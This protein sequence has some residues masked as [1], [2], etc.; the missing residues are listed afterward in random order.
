MAL[1]IV[2]A[3]MGSLEEE[4]AESILMSRY[5]DGLKVWSC[6]CPWIGMFCVASMFEEVV[7]NDQHRRI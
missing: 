6:V 7:V 2:D 4:S 1:S 5:Y 3:M